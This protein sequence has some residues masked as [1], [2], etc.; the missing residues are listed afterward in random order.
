MQAFKQSGFS[1][2]AFPKTFESYHIETNIMPSLL[3]IDIVGERQAEPFSLLRL[4]RLQ[5]AVLTC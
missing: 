3:D 5:Y 1:I 4:I 2:D